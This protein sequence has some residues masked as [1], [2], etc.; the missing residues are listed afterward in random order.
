MDQKMNGLSRDLIIHPGE[1]LI[2][3]LEDQEMSQ[4]ELAVRTGVSEKHVSTIIK[5]VKPISVAYSKK[6]EYALG[7]DASFWINLQANYDKE[8]LEFEEAN[9]ISAEE[10]AILK[11]LKFIIGYLGE[12]GVMNP[13]DNEAAKVLDLRKIF[14]ISNLTAIPGMTY[15]A[16]YRAQIA[17]TADVYV[18]FAWQ[19][20]CEILTENIKVS[21]ELDI[22]KLR[23]RIPEI[24]QL[25]FS[26]VDT[27]CNKLKTIFADCGIAFEIVRHFTGAPVQGFIKKDEK[28]RTM[29]CMTLRQGFA[30]RFW[31]TLFHEIAHILHG[32]AK[33]KFIDFD[34]VVS[35]VEE[36]ANKYSR[37]I[38]LRPD[39][40]RRF[41][42][43]KDFSLPSI[44][45]FAETQKVRPFIIIGRLQKEGELAWNQYS[46]EMDIYQW[47]ST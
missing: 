22:N 21:D 36:R 45:K 10:I 7:I 38:L 13:N 43:K 8:L 18:L 5:G 3:I 15:N 46:G 1:T 25:M 37:N 17:T 14:K 26:R 2:E 44:Y 11:P 28:G 16:A 42:Q 12:L 29:L 34:S 19:R 40:Y 27:I 39:D 33:Q 30:D 6:L 23:E 41:V 47:A 35:E 9:N 24:K 31:F 20:I 32:D 4:K